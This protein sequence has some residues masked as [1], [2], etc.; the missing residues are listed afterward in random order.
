VNSSLPTIR[1]RQERESLADSACLQNEQIPQLL[2]DNYP[3]DYYSVE[4]SFAQVARNVERESQTGRPGHFDRCDTF[5][6]NVGYAI[7]VDQSRQNILLQFPAP[8]HFPAAARRGESIPA[9]AGR[10]PFVF[11]NMVTGASRLA[12]AAQ[13]G[14]WT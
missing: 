8:L 3:R 14:A 11:R 5:D 10:N 2:G 4:L 1:R 9:R 13:H 6:E 12:G 7:G